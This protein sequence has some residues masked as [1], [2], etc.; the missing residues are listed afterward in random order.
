MRI[1]DLFTIY[2]RRLVLNSYMKNVL[3]SSRCEAERQREGMC[4]GGGGG[5][6][7]EE[8]ALRLAVA[9]GVNGG[10]LSPGSS[11]GGSSAGSGP[12]AGAGGSSRTM[13]KAKSTIGPARSASD[14][15][16]LPLPPSPSSRAHQPPLAPVR[17]LRSSVTATAPPP[18][19][20]TSMMDLGPSS[21]S[22]I[23]RVSPGSTLGSISIG[24]ASSLHLQDRTTDLSLFAGKKELQ[25]LQAR[26]VSSQM[27]LDILSARASLT[28]L[29][30]PC[31]SGGGSSPRP[32][33]DVHESQWDHLNIEPSSPP[34][35]SLPHLSQVPYLT[36]PSSQRT[37]NKKYTDREEDGSDVGGPGGLGGRSPPSSSPQLQLNSL[38]LSPRGLRSRESHHAVSNIHVLAGAEREREGVRLPAILSPTHTKKGSKGH[39]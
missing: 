14:T 23:S 11:I 36:S 28:P 29:S 37:S 1:I 18:H 27:A 26:G 39:P 33:N 30:S 31:L 5:G 15:S 6:M 10:L 16:D 12:G 7:K 4:G 25:K 9:R 17:V 22:S 2:K 19:Q 20:R 24:D 34:S 21:T 3:V 8:A 32:Y 35:G 38:R 13:V